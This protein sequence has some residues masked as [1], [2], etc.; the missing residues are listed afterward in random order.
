MED[1]VTVPTERLTGGVEAAELGAWP[2]SR[3]QER[4]GFTKMIDAG[5]MLPSIGVM[6]TSIAILS[7]FGILLLM[8][9]TFLPGLIAGSIG[10]LSLLA[11]VWLALTAEELDAW[12]GS[13][14]VSLV[15]GI[16]FFATGMMAVWL[17]WFAVKF[18]R[19]SF[20]LDAAIESSVG[21]IPGAP[22]G[23][24]GVAVTE[25]RPLGRAEFG[26]KRYE[27]RCQTGHLAAGTRIEVI[28]AEFGSLIVRPV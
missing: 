8:L 25:L 23:S 24:Q 13:Q 9:E 22:P 19:R 10:A 28:S 21:G 16:L 26:G 14:R 27:V 5:R 18:F 2:A 15:V 4:T 12:S 11:A 1:R 6:L 3:P 20:T 17:R 7:L